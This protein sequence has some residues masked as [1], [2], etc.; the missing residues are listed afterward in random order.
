M[1]ARGG[2]DTSAP[3]FAWFSSDGCWLHFTRD[4]SQ[5][6]RVAVAALR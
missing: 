6:M 1:T 5:L 2:L 4:Y 3:N